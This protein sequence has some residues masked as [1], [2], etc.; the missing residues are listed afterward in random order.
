MDKEKIKIITFTGNSGI[1][2]SNPTVH[3]SLLT[4]YHCAPNATWR[5]GMAVGIDMIVA[6]YAYVHLIPFEAHL[7]FPAEIQTKNWSMFDRATHTAMVGY[8][9]SVK[10]H[11]QEFNMAGYQKRNEAMA[12]DA[13]VVVAFNLNK[14]GGTVNMIKYCLAKNIP[15]LDGFDDLKVIKN[16]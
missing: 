14:R 4:V 15:I 2:H 1:H 6:R 5:T 12:Q 11:S 3:K 9:D 8:A 7:P 16:I 13:D 10:V